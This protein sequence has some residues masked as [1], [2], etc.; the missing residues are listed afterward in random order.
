[1][2]VVFGRSLNLGKC[3]FMRRW[4]DWFTLMGSKKKQVRKRKK[5]LIHIIYILAYINEMYEISLDVSAGSL[6]FQVCVS[7]ISEFKLASSIKQ[8]LDLS[9]YWQR[10]DNSM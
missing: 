8:S 9:S 10:G 2:T 4:V 6:L 1:M 3:V 5:Q 7:A